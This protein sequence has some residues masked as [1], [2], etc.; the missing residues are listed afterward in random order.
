ML[1]LE[2]FACAA[3]VVVGTAQGLFEATGRDGQK[4][5]RADDS[6]QRA[7]ATATLFFLL[8]SPCLAE[9]RAAGKKQKK[10]VQT[11]EP[12]AT[13]RDFASIARNAA[14][15]PAARFC[16]CW[17]FFHRAGAIVG[18]SPNTANGGPRQPD[19]WAISVVRLKKGMATCGR[20]TNG[21]QVDRTT[22]L[23]T[24][25]GTMGPTVL[26]FP[27][28]LP[29]LALEAAFDAYLQVASPPAGVAMACRRR[30]LAQ[31]APLASVPEFGR[32]ARRFARA[33]PPKM[34]LHRVAGGIALATSWEGCD[35]GAPRLRGCGTLTLVGSC[36]CGGKNAAACD[37]V[38]GM[39]GQL[40]RLYVARVL[41]HGAAQDARCGAL[42]DGDA[43]ADAQ[44]VVALSRATP[45][46]VVDA[47]IVDHRRRRHTKEPTQSAVVLIEACDRYFVGMSVGDGAHRDDD[48]RRFVE[49]V[50]E[51][52]RHGI[53]VVATVSDAT[54]AAAGAG[55]LRDAI[56][57]FV[58][59]VPDAGRC[60]D[61]ARLF[62]PL[63]CHPLASLAA[64]MTGVK[65]YDALVFEHAPVETVSAW[66]R[67]QVPR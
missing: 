34:P 13:A 27:G 33:W 29:S 23:C 7:I 2:G 14:S 36:D 35:L 57:R 18:R 44:H 9:E 32:A 64:L 41:G 60:T 42:S 66:M 16:W 5:A 30:W 24:P 40:G 11:S 67:R 6:I 3:S 45:A 31:H 26:A 1:S 38:A 50:T 15:G 55:F 58:L 54:A 53:H 63:T 48:M 62:A 39:Q 43:D 37:L 49:S 65:R 8:P 12:P 21:I 20:G 28:C 4:R 47:V 10:D 22:T 46:D 59:V 51:A 17:G 25:A 52:K 56:D 19:R 61:V